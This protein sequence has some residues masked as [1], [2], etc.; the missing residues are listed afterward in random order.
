MDYTEV[1]GE[2]LTFEP[3]QFRACTQV[4]IVDDR[5]LEPVE[6]FFVSATPQMD[7]R[8]LTVDPDN[9]TVCIVDN[10]KLITN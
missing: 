1:D 10:G 5:L 3:G 2:V 9:T 4:S 7:G 8:S 6:C